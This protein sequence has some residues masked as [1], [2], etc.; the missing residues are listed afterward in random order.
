MQETKGQNLQIDCDKRMHNLLEFIKKYNYW[1]LFFVLE[2]ISLV[3]LFRFNRYQGSVWF[4]SANEVAAKVNSY[5]TEMVA[6]IQLKQVNKELAIQNTRLQGQVTDLREALREATKVESKNDIQVKDSLK[7]YDL[8]PAKVVSNSILKNENYIIIDRGEN[9]GVK[10]EMG[11]IGGGG[12]VGIIV[13]TNRNYSLVLPI[14][15]I[16][17]NI[18]CRIRHNRYF[19]YLQWT[20]GSTLFANLN[21]IPRY[22]K[23]KIGE[24]VETSGYSTVFPPGIF[25][26]K[27]KSVSNAPDGLSLQLKVNLGTNFANLSDVCVVV[28]K[29][30]PEIDSL[31]INLMNGENSDQ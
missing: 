10:P 14:I 11:V 6:F 18:S 24:Y 2:I 16:K 13:Y 3:L 23:I 1:F 20:G 17:S 27:V 19:G 15:N 22:A 30:R 9:D 25:V 21:D 29:N 7:G 5:Y 12:V 4:T 26:G 31:R 28:N 8:I